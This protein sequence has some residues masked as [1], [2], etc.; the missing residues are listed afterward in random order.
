MEGSRKLSTDEILIVH[1]ITPVLIDVTTDG[2]ALSEST[3][4]IWARFPH[5][6]TDMILTSGVKFFNRLE[7]VEGQ[8]K[9]LSLEVIYMFDSIVPAFPPPRDAPL[10]LD[11]SI[12]AGARRSYKCIAWHV[13]QFGVIV[14]DD[15]P[16][17]DDPKSVKEVEERNYAWI[18]RRAEAT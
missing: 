11:F 2:R 7:L 18:G 4:R 1:D 12:V 14:R 6:G 8:W 10:D 16:G 9:M 15:L 13:A 5:E 17:A 3:G